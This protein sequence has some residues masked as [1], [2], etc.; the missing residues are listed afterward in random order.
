MTV[1]TSSS[2]YGVG[3]SLLVRYLYF[4]IWL[5]VRTS[6]ISIFI[7]FATSA[8]PRNPVPVLFELSCDTLTTCSDFLSVSISLDELSTLLSLYERRS[9]IDLFSIIELDSSPYTLTIS[10]LPMSSYW[11]SNCARCCRGFWELNCDIVAN[12]LSLSSIWL[13]LL[14]S[15]IVYCPYELIRSLFLFISLE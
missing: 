14:F 12:F 13:Y 9:P 7:F 5:A 4:A 6:L 1:G 11:V 3:H 2:A 15:L 8:D 10:S